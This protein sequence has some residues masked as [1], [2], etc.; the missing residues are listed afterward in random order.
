M[1]TLDKDLLNEWLSTMVRVFVGAGM[2]PADFAAAVVA[3]V[4]DATDAAAVLAAL[5]AHIADAAA[6][7]A[8]SAIG[9]NG[10]PALE[11]GSWG[12][13]KTKH[14]VL[15]D[16][17]YVIRWPVGTGG[18][19][20]SFAISKDG[21]V[22][23]FLRSGGDDNSASYNTLVY[24]SAAGTW[25]FE[26]ALGVTIPVLTV[27]GVRVVPNN[28]QATAAPTAAENTAAGYPNGA[29]WTEVDASKLWV[30][31]SESA[32]TAVWLS[33]TLA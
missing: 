30:K 7:H 23:R 27:G 12:G 10:V 19:G 8:A 14:I 11:S 2:T 6:A 1:A 17:S 28:V 13:G 29:L 32:G 4:G 21:D 16:D 5:T 20:T 24:N 26:D 22:W 33:T 31:V 9:T 3:D 25:S 18:G 15:P